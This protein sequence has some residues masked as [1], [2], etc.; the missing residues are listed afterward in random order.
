MKH[1]ALILGVL[2]FTTITVAQTSGDVMKFKTRIGFEADESIEQTRI[3]DNRAKVALVGRKTI[4]IWDLIN[5]KLLNSFP[6]EIKKRG[7]ERFQ[8]S[9]DNRFLIGI[10]DRFV[11]LNLVKDDR[12]DQALIYDLSTGKQV[13]ALQRPATPIRT[14]EWSANGQ[15]IV[16]FSN[17]LQKEVE[18][19][20]WNGSD[21]AWRSSLNVKGYSWHYLTRDGTYLYVGSGGLTFFEKVYG[22]Y[23]GST[24]RVYNTITGK[25][26]GELT[27][28]AKYKIAHGRTFVS[29]DEKF[30]ATEGDRKIVVWNLSERSSRVAPKYEITPTDPKKKLSLEGVSYDGLFWIATDKDAR[31]YYE[32]A[33]GKPVSKVPQ[34]VD[35]KFN[36]SNLILVPKT[37]YAIV[38]DCGGARIIDLQTNKLVTDVKFKCQSGTSE[39]GS[40]WS[41][42]DDFVIPNDDGTLLL[43]FADVP[44][45]K[46]REL[47]IRNLNS[48]AILETLS[49][50][51]KPPIKAYEPKWGP[52]NWWFKDNYVFAM[53]QDE[54]TILI[55]ETKTAGS[56]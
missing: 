27:A 13:G 26:E 56:N 48:G 50:P 47:K 38:Q 52:G 32:T 33:T 20:Y 10:R 24:V 14:A 41:Y 23:T 2:F 22:S 37:D 53:S 15:T 9:P 28:D 35:L 17:T 46:E 39:D 34:L 55:W 19:S 40:S 1:V 5:A 30:L 12:P 51:G 42:T 16:T 49:F 45:S 44:K 8:M 11:P 4:Q 25:L 36:Y 29:P 3:L 7:G 54:R 43:D 31:V 18:I 6:H 21:F